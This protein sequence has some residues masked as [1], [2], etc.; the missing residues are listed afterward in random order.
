MPRL[1][2]TPCLH[3]TEHND[4]EGETWHF[5]VPLA[6]NEEAVTIVED[7][8]ACFKVAHERVG[9]PGDYPYTSA[10]ENLHLP[11]LE[12]LSDDRGYMPAHNIIP[13]LDLAKVRA[14]DWHEVEPQTANDEHPLL[15]D[16]LYKGGL[17]DL[18]ED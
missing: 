7:F 5:Y 17:R 16:P 15:K 9:G 3:L 6:G 18:A 8:L 10:R 14:V 13:K 2:L 12:R 1:K 4:W 11:T